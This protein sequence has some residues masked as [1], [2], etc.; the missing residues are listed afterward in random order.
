VRARLPLT[1]VLV[2]LLVALQGCSGGGGVKYAAVTG[3]VLMDGKPLA[4]AAVT[5][6]PI[7]KPGSDIAGDTASGLTD[8]NGQYTL[9][10][11]TKDGW[12]DGAIVGKHRV[13]ISKTETRG[14]GDRSVTMQLLPKKYNEYS[15]L[16]E[17][18]AAGSNQKD[19][20]LKSR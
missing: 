18:V 14:E 11:I 8:E 2:S 13:S 20:E 9:R 17:D 4:K 12:K 1:L 5:F 6:V 3:K 15:E 16:T 7:P 19:F 10:T